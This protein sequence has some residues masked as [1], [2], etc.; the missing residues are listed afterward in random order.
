MCTEQAINYV[1][2]GHR[3]IDLDKCEAAMKS[4]KAHTRGHGLR[5]ANTLEKEGRC[6]ECAANFEKQQQKL[7]KGGEEKANRAA[8]EETLQPQGAWASRSGPKKE[9]ADEQRKLV[10]E[11][12]KKQPTH[13]HVDKAVAQARNLNKETRS[14]STKPRHQNE[15]DEQRRQ[16]R[17]E[18][19]QRRFSDGPHPEAE[20]PKDI[21][22]PR[23][24]NMYEYLNFDGDSDILR[25][26]GKQ[27]TKVSR[28]K[29]SKHKQHPTRLYDRD[30]SR[31]EG[32]SASVDA[33]EA[34]PSVTGE[35]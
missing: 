4:G 19:L 5:Q 23:F 26:G 25:D 2:C 11:N 20:S 14:R 10:T 34:K 28:P 16:N 18:R 8:N 13:T 30:T 33:H 35:D 32:A 21:S 17:V 12:R 1:G 7:L 29:W 6:A 24:I 9:A 15:P 31:D 22:Q 3:D 27:T